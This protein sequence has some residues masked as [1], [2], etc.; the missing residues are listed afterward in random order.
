[1]Q[2]FED[3]EEEI[4]CKS[5]SQSEPL[6]EALSSPSITRYTTLSREDGLGHKRMSVHGFTDDRA[7][8]LMILLSLWQPC[9]IESLH[10][11]II[12]LYWDG[13]CYLYLTNE[14]LSF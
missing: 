14:N 7:P 6:E 4:L 2:S 3:L 13:F 5:I 8:S 12:F 10:P 11:L 9:G 1:M